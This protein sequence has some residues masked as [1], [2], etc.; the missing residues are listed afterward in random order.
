V[1]R[2]CG[3]P[4]GRVVEIIEVAVAKDCRFHVAV[5]LLASVQSVGQSTVIGRRSRAECSTIAMVSYVR[6]SKGV[7]R[8]IVVICLFCFVRITEPCCPK[9]V[10]YDVVIIR[11]ML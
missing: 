9:D 11:E 10:S 7:Y 4:N 6:K 3:V 2:D 8:I 5:E 1:V